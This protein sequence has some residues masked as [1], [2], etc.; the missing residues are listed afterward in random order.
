M[1]SLSSVLA[2]QEIKLGKNREM[3]EYAIYTTAAFV[4]PFMIAQPQLVVGTLV[5]AALILSAL[6]LKNAK[7][8]PVILLPSVAVLSRGLIFGPFTM[9]LLYTIPFIWIGNSALVY[10]IKRFYLG[11]KW[12]KY[13]SL[14]LGIVAKVLFL[15][16]AANILIKLGVLPKVFA[17]AM[18]VFQLYTAI[19]GSVLALSVAALTNKLTL[20]RN[21]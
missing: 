1:D 15:Y 5:N 3:T 6:N 19:A 21:T 7:L 14:A 4:V 2:L 10:I 9:Y 17:T 8:L 13:L 12:N 20:S 16:V 11:A 18:G